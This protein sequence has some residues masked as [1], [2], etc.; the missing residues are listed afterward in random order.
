M[1]ETRSRSIAVGGMPTENCT[2]KIVYIEQLGACRCDWCQPS[3]KDFLHPQVNEVGSIGGR[4]RPTVSH[5]EPDYCHTHE[6]TKS[7]LTSASE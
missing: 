6:C 4:V 7:I 2:P 3:A 5:D 1:N